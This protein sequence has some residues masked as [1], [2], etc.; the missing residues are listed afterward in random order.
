MSQRKSAG[1]VADE[2]DMN[3]FFRLPNE[4]ALTGRPEANWERKCNDSCKFRSFGDLFECQLREQ[5][6]RLTVAGC[7]HVSIQH[8]CLASIRSFTAHVGL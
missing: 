8:G 6:S 4:V 3:S 2:L 5:A 1:I 7:I